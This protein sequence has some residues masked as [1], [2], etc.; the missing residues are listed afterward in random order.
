[1][2]TVWFCLVAL[3]LTMYVVLDGFDLG[4]GAIHLL[5]A[6][7]EEE[8]RLALRAIGPVWDGNEVWLLVAAAT[9]FFAFP[10]L[11]ASAFSGFYLP[12]MIILWLLI[13]RGIAIEFRNHIQSPAW[14]PLWDT[15]YS[16]ASGLLIIFFGTALG[17]VVRGVSLDENGRFFT[18]LWTNLR[19]GPD[20]GVMDWYTLSV[21]ATALFAM[22]MHGALWLN[23]KTRSDLQARTQRMAMAAWAGTGIL[24]AIITFMTFRVQ[25]QVAANMT[26]HPWGWMFP[27]LAMAGW[28]GVRLYLRSDRELP[29]F[30]AS[31]GYIMGMMSSVAFGLYPYVLPAIAGQ[32]TSLTVTNTAAPAGGLQMALIWWIPG[33]LLATGYA[34]FVYHHFAGKVSTETDGSTSRREPAPQD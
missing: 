9:L 30:L 24:T 26:A 32:G 27:L 12:L 21:G 10:A 23:L 1:L 13:L 16:G 25:P 31:C 18:P 29:A 15:V 11:Y 3:V 2:E 7:T 4:A 33:M 17:N 8:R 5:V 14:T 28:I 6:K 20:P 34:I 22:A 19:P